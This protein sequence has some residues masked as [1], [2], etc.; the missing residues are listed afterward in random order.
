MKNRMCGNRTI[1]GLVCIILA[2]AVTFGAAP[3]VN[4][5][6]DKKVEIIRMSKDVPQGSQITEADITVIEVGSYNLPEN[7]IRDKN[8]V[9]GKYAATGLQAGDYL[10]PGKLN[11]DA[12]SADNV[13][14]SLDGTKQAVSIAINSFSAGLSGKLRN[15]DIVGII[16]TAN[17]KNEAEAP[18]ALRY[19]KVITATTA[20]G[21]DT[22][23]LTKNENGTY[24]LPST[25]TLLVTVEQAKLLAQYEAKGKIHIS[26][27]Y[28]GDTQTAQKFLDVQDE[29]L[30]TVQKKEVVSGE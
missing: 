16:V 11:D 10:L 6:S 26:L 4:R 13:F 21:V 24:E 20:G 12:D 9:V 22:D 15:G 5:L 8:A 29:Y 3:L 27:V 23:Q 2:A 17:D 7:I 14:R 19:L 18:A 28:R 25:V 30:K 1:I